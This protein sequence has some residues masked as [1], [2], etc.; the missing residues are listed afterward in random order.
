MPWKRERL[1]VPIEY[2]GGILKVGKLNADAQALLDDFI[3]VAKLARATLPANAIS[4][5]ASAAPHEHPPALKNG[6]VAV[7]VYILK[8][9][10]LKVGKVGPKSHARYVS[11]HYNPSSSISNLAKSILDD[12]NNMGLQHLD[13]NDVGNW[14]RS[15]TDRVNFVLSGENLIPVLNLL[16]AFLQ[17]RLKPR[18][19]GF[20]SQK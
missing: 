19:E 16:E 6:D 17:C 3:K 8:G 18:F 14:I 9:D 10:C 5:V 4:I 1:A 2:G 15:Y 7:Y 20:K 13:E 12:R 11:H